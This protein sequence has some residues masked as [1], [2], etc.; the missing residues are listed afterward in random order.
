MPESENK[1]I[2]ISDIVKAEPP[3]IQISPE[4]CILKIVA[5]QISDGFE[6]R[7]FGLVATYPSGLIADIAKQV[8]DESYNN[9]SSDASVV[10]GIVGTSHVFNEA[11]L[12]EQPW[13]KKPAEKQVKR[14]ERRAAHMVLCLLGLK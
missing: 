4:G 6:S 14:A 5:Y 8:K 3:E 1:Q 13:Y 9:L 10:L 12:H 11:V 7:P 2:P